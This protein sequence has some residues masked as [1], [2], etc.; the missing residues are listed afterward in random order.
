MILFLAHDL[1]L[2]RD[3]DSL[4]GYCLYL[5]PYN[6]ICNWSVIENPSKFISAVL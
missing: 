6:E 2:A 5:N 3:K 1:P 4:N